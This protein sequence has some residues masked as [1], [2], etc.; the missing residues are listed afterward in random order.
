MASK[1]LALLI[2][3]FVSATS[4]Q[5]VAQGAGGSGAAAGAGGSAAAATGGAAGSGSAAT[6]GTA[7]TG[8]TGMSQT[9]TQPPQSSAPAGSPTALQA[10]RNA[11]AGTAPN[12]LP[13]GSPGSGLGSPEHPV[14][15]GR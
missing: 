5:A 15:S 8:T 6:G 14:G 7:D 12:G 9:N 11:G 1:K 4:L 3:A 13:I 10:A 2:V